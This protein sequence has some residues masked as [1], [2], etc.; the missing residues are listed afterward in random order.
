MKNTPNAIPGKSEYVADTMAMVLHLEQRRL[1][2]E[3]KRIFGLADEGKALIHIPA[4]VVAEILYLSEK[5]RI[6]IDLQD[7]S[8]Y[9][10]KP[11]YMEQPLSFDIIQA[12]CR[13]DDIPELHD[14]LIA[15]TAKALNLPIVTNDPVIQASRYVTTVW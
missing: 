14:R 3:V 1:S 4:M 8:H 5:Q 2:P 10:Q 13:I 15:A 6:D 7:V 9:L 12:A 11:G